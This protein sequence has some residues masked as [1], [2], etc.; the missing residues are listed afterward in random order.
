MRISANPG[1]TSSVYLRIMNIL[2]ERPRRAS[3]VLEELAKQTGITV[4]R[5]MVY[6]YLHNMENIGMIRGEKFGSERNGYKKLRWHSAI[7][8]LDL[9]SKI[10]AAVAELCPHLRGFVDLVTGPPVATV[11]T[12]NKPHGPQDFSFVVTVNQS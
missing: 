12:E 1:I 6:T 2:Y 4:T 7:S 9:I 3:E 8:P 11:A 5:N 10:K